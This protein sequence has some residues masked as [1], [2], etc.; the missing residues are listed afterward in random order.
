MKSNDWK[1]L[2]EIVGIAAIVASLILVAYEI[3][4][5]S[6]FVA[7][8]TGAARYFAAI[9]SYSTLALNAELAQI[10]M[11]SCS[12]NAES[13]TELE[14][15][16]V[17]NWTLR[18][19]LLNQWGY[20]SIPQKEYLPFLEMQRSN[21]QNCESYRQTLESNRSFFEP[22]FLKFLEENVF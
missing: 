3:R 7:A 5:N 22:E 11:T 14:K 1:E 2:V 15:H 12:E 21:H 4:Q 19:L 10:M 8:D 6:Q 18:V 9:E 20:K 13:L 16:R 17:T